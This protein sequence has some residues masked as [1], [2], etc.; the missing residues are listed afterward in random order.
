MT[1]LDKDNHYNPGIL[2][3][4]YKALKGQ[5]CEFAINSLRVGDTYMRHWNESSLV[6]VTAWHL[7]GA[8]PLPEP[9]KTYCQLD[10]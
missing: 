5:G 7:L 6:Q 8:K 10:L 9:M 3:L 1:R 2:Q 4:Q